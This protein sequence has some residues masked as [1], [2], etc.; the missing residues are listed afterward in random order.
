MFAFL[1]FFP[2]W[3]ICEFKTS[4]SPRLPLLREPEGILSLTV[5]CY[6]TG[7]RF[8]SSSLA[9]RQPSLWERRNYNSRRMP[10]ATL[11]FSV[12]NDLPPQR[13][14]SDPDTLKCLHVWFSSM[15]TQQQHNIL[16]IPREYNPTPCHSPFLVIRL[17]RFL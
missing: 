1:S 17:T 11:F 2:Q 15:L 5:T 12:C 3:I 8:C 7:L 6:G 9:G 10:G 13:R 16:C 4:V 14:P